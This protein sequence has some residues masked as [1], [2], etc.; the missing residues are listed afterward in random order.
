SSRLCEREDCMA[1][2]VSLHAVVDEMEMLGGEEMHA[3]LNRQTGELYGGTTDLLTKAEEG[4]DEELLEW[5][6]EGIDG[7][8]EVLE[9]PDWL[10]LPRRD[11]HEDYRIM[12]R[13]CLEECQG[14]LQEDLLSAMTGRGAFRRFKDAIHRHGVHEAWYAFRRAW[15]TEE[16]REWLEA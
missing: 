16:A 9:S 5:E 3:F 1:A 7:L 8:R 14:R 10:E 11:S 6:V 15:L 4:D 2:V 12:E 13:F